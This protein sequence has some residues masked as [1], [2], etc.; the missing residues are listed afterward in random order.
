[1]NKKKSSSSSTLSFLIMPCNKNILQG[2][3]MQEKI[4]NKL[5][6]K[7]GKF[8]IS[9]KEVAKELHCST[10]NIDRMRQSGEI[11]SKKVRGQIFFSLEEV[12][13]FLAEV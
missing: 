2:T 5:Y 9:K 6:E 7:Y 13:R 10:A 8:I 3:K 11:S 1:M 4:F 12:S